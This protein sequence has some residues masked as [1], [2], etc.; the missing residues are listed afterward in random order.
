MPKPSVF[1]SKL[2]SRGITPQRNRLTPLD[3]PFTAF[4]LPS[5]GKHRDAL[6]A[7]FSDSPDLTR[8]LLA[9]PVPRARSTLTTREFHSSDFQSLGLRESRS[10]WRS[11]NP[12]LGIIHLEFALR[13]DP[14][15]DPREME[16]QRSVEPPPVVLTARLLDIYLLPVAAA[17]EPSPTTIAAVGELISYQVYAH[18][19]GVVDALYSMHVDEDEDDLGFI[20]WEYPEL[21]RVEL[22]G[23]DRVVEH[24]RAL[25]HAE[26]AIHGKPHQDHDEVVRRLLP[27]DGRFD[28]ARR[29]RDNDFDLTL[30]IAI[31]G[32]AAYEKPRIARAKPNETHHLLIH[33]DPVLRLHGG[34]VINLSAMAA[35]QSR[36]DEKRAEREMEQFLLDEE[37]VDWGPGYDHRLA[38][39]KENTT[40]QPIKWVIVSDDG[41][42]VF[43]AVPVPA[44]EF[45][46]TR[47]ITTLDT[48]WSGQHGMLRGQPTNVSFP[49]AYATPGARSQIEWHLGQR[50]IKLVRPKSGFHTP[51]SLIK[52]WSDASRCM[53]AYSV[54]RDSTPSTVSWPFLES[55]TPGASTRRACPFVL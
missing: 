49:T 10:Q 33:T 41:T 26:A 17:H 46:L 22:Q 24:D 27:E 20:Y 5:Q 7:K 45:D 13:V 30:G 50:S 55:W 32:R 28:V 1:V 51:L 53:K 18:L 37:E 19:D 43:A 21:V 23:E 9:A 16:Y 44:S 12:L 25:I 15:L 52:T 3:S 31:K 36:A 2:R 6:L 47:L 34:R 11:E 4:T 8:S 40:H 42:G 35:M 39:M 29:P 14:Q 38:R 48:I 54:S